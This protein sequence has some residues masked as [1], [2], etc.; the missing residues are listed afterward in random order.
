MPDVDRHI[1]DFN[2]GWRDIGN[3]PSCS[4][5]VAF[6]DVLQLAFAFIPKDGSANAILDDQ[7]QIFITRNWRSRNIQGQPIGIPFHRISR[8]FDF[9]FFI[10]PSA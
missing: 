8:A 9:D 4:K 10:A 6:A 1:K 5:L 2:F 7:P 3:L